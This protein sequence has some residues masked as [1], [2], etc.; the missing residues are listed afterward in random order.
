MNRFYEDLHDWL[1]EHGWTDWEDKWD[2]YETFYLEKIDKGGFKEVWIKWRPHRIPEKNSYYR[3][4]LDLD[5][6]CIALKDTEIV[7]EGKKLKVQKGE[8]ELFVTAIMELDYKGEW[9]NHPILKFFNKLFP[10]RIFKKEIF[11]EHKRELYREAYELQNY[12]KQWFK[13]K[14]HL[15]YEETKSFAPSYAWP[16]HMQE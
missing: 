10:E 5:F 7:K 2:H 4:W 9:S 14:R 13:M 8:V 15:P 3:Y 1:K 12:I 6:H 11:G 16:S